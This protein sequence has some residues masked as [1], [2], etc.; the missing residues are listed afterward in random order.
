MSKGKSETSGMAERRRERRKGKSKT[1]GRQ[2]DTTSAKKMSG[3]V[4]PIGFLCT[5]LANEGISDDG[6]KE[7][8]EELLPYYHQKLVRLLQLVF[9]R[10]SARP[11]L[12]GFLATNGHER[13]GVP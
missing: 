4:D 5:V 2:M 12:D 9:I 1:R 13:R 7:A 3:G 8:A 11:C 6:R 10:L